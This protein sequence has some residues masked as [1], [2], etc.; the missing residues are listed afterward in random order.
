MAQTQIS[1]QVPKIKLSLQE[2]ETYIHDFNYLLFTKNELLPFKFTTDAPDLLNLHNSEYVP[3]GTKIAYRAE[4][5]SEN[6]TQVRCSIENTA[7]NNL[8]SLI[9]TRPSDVEGSRFYVEVKKLVYSQSTPWD[10]DVSV[11]D[12]FRINLKENNLGSSTCTSTVLINELNRV[13]L[14]CSLSINNQFYVVMLCSDNSCSEKTE[15]LKITE[16]QRAQNIENMELMR[17]PGISTS[18]FSMLFYFGNTPHVEYMVFDNNGHIESTV[19]TLNFNINNVRYFSGQLLVIEGLDKNGKEMIAYSFFD[20]GIYRVNFDKMRL[21]EMSTF[22]KFANS[23]V[24]PMTGEIII[25]LLSGN[26]LADLS[27]DRG[28]YE[29]AVEF[30]KVIPEADKKNLMIFEIGGSYQ[31]IAFG[32]VT[33]HWNLTM[34]LMANKNR[35]LK[36][37]QADLTEVTNN[38]EDLTK[39]QGFYQVSGCRIKKGDPTD[40]RTWAI[41][42]YNLNFR[43][44][45]LQLNANPS[46]VAS[47]TDKKPFSIVMTS[48]QTNENLLEFEVEVIPS[49][50]F[51][52]GKKWLVLDKITVMTDEVATEE[53]MKLS[54]VIQG[55]FLAISR[56]KLQSGQTISYRNKINPLLNYMTLAM[57][58]SSSPDFK[59]PSYH[60]CS[61]IV[62]I[63]SLYNLSFSS[64]VMAYKDSSQSVSV[65]ESKGQNV[66]ATYTDHL[67][68]GFNIFEPFNETLFIVHSEKGLYLYDTVKAMP[69][70]LVFDS[71]ACTR[72]ILLHHSTLDLTLWCIAKNM[73]SVYYARDLIEGKSGIRKL[74]MTLQTSFDGLQLVTNEHFPDYIFALNSGHTMTVIKVEAQSNLIVKEAGQF[75]LLPSNNG[76][77]TLNLKFQ[78]QYLLLY[79]ARRIGYGDQIVLNFFIFTNPLSPLHTKTIELDFMFSPDSKNNEIYS[80]AKENKYFSTEVHSISKQML[81]IPVK[82]KETFHN[83]LFIDPKAP[84]SNTI[85]I[86]LFSMESQVHMMTVG[87]SLHSSSMDFN[88]GL[89]IYYSYK[90]DGVKHSVLSKVTSV[91]SNLRLNAHSEGNIYY[92]INNVGQID[93]YRLETIEFEGDVI[94]AARAPSLN[95]TII[96]NS[97]SN[98]RTKARDTIIFSNPGE[99]VIDLNEIKDNLNSKKNNSLDKYIFSLIDVSH[100]MT[101]NVFSWTL[102]IESFLE[103]LGKDI[104]LKTLIRKQKTTS[105]EE[106]TDGMKFKRM[107]ENCTNPS[108]DFHSLSIG[109]QEP[110][111][112]TVDLTLCV[113][114]RNM[115]VYAHIHDPAVPKPLAHP[116]SNQ[117]TTTNQ[118]YIKI[119]YENRLLEVI[120]LRRPMGRKVFA[121][122]FYV[123]FSLSN[124]TEHSLTLTK[125]CR[126]FF[127]DVSS[128]YSVVYL[129]NSNKK[130][131]QFEYFEWIL[132][133]QT[134]LGYQAKMIHEKWSLNLEGNRNVALT[135]NTSIAFTILQKIY[136]KGQ[137]MEILDRFTTTMVDS[138]DPKY[139]WLMIEHSSM[140]SYI[141]RFSKEKVLKA[142]PYTIKPDVWRLDNPMYGFSDNGFEIKS[143]KSDWVIASIKMIRDICYLII[144]IVPDDCFKET[145]ESITSIYSK[146]IAT[147]EEVIDFTIEKSTIH[148]R[149]ISSLRHLSLEH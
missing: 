139:L 124:S 38:T 105:L 37:S 68:I 134:N 62:M 122:Y 119:N 110:R 63:T 16:Y 128:D 69:Q 142:I 130:V 25:E 76:L 12:V 78:D 4:L 86:T 149:S 75:G 72:I 125:L 31:M 40:H 64:Q 49:S 96:Y 81:A 127:S 138:E 7:R 100:L 140:D 61:A 136:E 22:G 99:L 19:Y 84:I 56:M 118:N 60:N 102:D 67:K 87:I 46:L 53:E 3:L 1:T 58:N 135:E 59:Y 52:L 133:A 89:A 35:M 65:Y 57:S 94:S 48:K 101:G 6:F 13:V 104:E 17:M 39:V 114:S 108:R 20:F 11:V 98:K 2:R 120:S 5:S 45:Y 146:Q 129:N 93:G 141:L 117:M 10:Y 55:N 109:D 131:A 90:E 148:E 137:K 8:V 18:T 144:Y 91:P 74:P 73:V 28:T 80:I 42:I 115:V 113:D 147:F 92:S 54:D 70:E 123:E 29:F 107:A 41:E 121:D 21:R 85:P 36:A 44:P 24:S 26:T 143:Q 32:T 30:S 106:L 112:V 132:A 95:V 71:G 43:V 51:K 34:I 145:P 83:I 103:T 14:V 82:V 33:N 79:Q 66:E 15:V 47:K 77:R 50:E 97:I 111:E 27:L 9:Y 126:K 116:V 88:Y 23:F